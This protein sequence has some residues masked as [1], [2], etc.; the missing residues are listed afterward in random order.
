M[1]NKITTI[2]IFLV[3]VFAVL[4]ML[5]QNLAA[6]IVFL[7][8]AATDGLDGY[9][10][11]KTGTVTRLGKFL[12][13]LADKLLIITAIICMVDKG[14]FSVVAAIL[15]I[16]RE[17]IITAF[18]TV[19]MGEGIELAADNLGKIKT[20]IQIA[21]VIVVMWSGGKFYLNEIFIAAATVITVVS[22]I[23]Y[24]L[25]NKAVLR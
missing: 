21:A 17:L 8:A 4:Y 9:I 10:A 3:P 16:A 6:G 2:R 15:I 13:P 5:S 24:I 7:V 1:A 18:R 23:N 11:R 22:G 25:K 14:T 20:I 12:D 19:A